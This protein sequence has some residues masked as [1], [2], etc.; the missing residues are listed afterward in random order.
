MPL[1]VQCRNIILHYSAITA[2][3]LGRKHIE[4][5]VAAVW[6]AV[7]LM[8]ALFAK[9]LATLSTEEMLRMPSF[10]QRGNTFLRN[11]KETKKQKDKSISQTMAL[12]IDVLVIHLKLHRCSRHIEG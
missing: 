10:L 6:F 3:A 4:I 11:E 5:I 12:V 2:I 1:R 8:E 9:L 7:A